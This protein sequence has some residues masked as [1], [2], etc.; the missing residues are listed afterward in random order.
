MDDLLCCKENNITVLET[1]NPDL[2]GTFVELGEDNFVIDW[3][4][5][6]HHNADYIVEDKYKTVNI[7]KFSE[8]FVSSVLNVYLNKNI[9]MYK[10]KDPFENVMELI[11]HENT[12]IIK[13]L[14][15]DGQKWFEIDDI[16]DLKKAEKIF[17]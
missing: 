12:N 11:V 9:E 3:T 13:G 10:G 16:E 5:K 1:Y 2:D 7:H 6:T 14:V 8:Q 4:H 17:S 15:L